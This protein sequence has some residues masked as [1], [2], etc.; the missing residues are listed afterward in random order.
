MATEI[1]KTVDPGGTGDYPSLAAAI[2]GEVIARPNLVANDEQLTLK[3]QCTNGAA[4]TSY[5][6]VTGFTTDATRFIKIWT[7]PTESYRHNG[8]YQTGNKYRYQ[9]DSGYRDQQMSI[10]VDYCRVIGIQFVNNQTGNLSRMISPQDET[11]EL[12]IEQNLFIDVAGANTVGTAI[13]DN[14]T[15]NINPFNMYIS[16]NTVIDMVGDGMSV[17]A[18]KSG[19]LSGAVYCHN[20]TII[21]SGDIGIGA[22]GSGSGRAVYIKNNII[23]RSTGGDYD[24][25]G[26]YEG[27]SNNVS[28]DATSPDGPAYQNRNIT[29]VDE[30]GND[31]HLDCADTGARDLGVNLYTDPDYPV[32]ID[33]DGDPRPTTGPYNCGSDACI[34]SQRTSGTKRYRKKLRGNFFSNRRT[35]RIVGPFQ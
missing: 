27:T 11:R 20:N 2:A 29:F 21:D 16:N 31:F 5:A 26:N 7:D 12:Y 19:G 14:C 15:D 25:I 4:D 34:S 24:T 22:R 13:Y 8:T 35:S 3:C 9:H 23:S 10:Q 17:S 32:T 1:I 33:I 30:A 6:I 28:G 18:F